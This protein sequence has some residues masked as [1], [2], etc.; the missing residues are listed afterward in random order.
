M[1]KE[2]GE[3]AIDNIILITTVIKLNKLDAS[4]FVSDFLN[5][6]QGIV[7]SICYSMV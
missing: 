7:G 6:K 3:R 5:L 2:G 1:I 4:V